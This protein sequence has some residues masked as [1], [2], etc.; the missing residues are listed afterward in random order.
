TRLTEVLGTGLRRRVDQLRAEHGLPPMGC[1]PNWFTARLPL[2]LVG[3]V[4]E[5]DYHRR[6]LSPSVHYVGDC[7]WH[8]PTE[9]GDDECLD[10]LSSDRAWV[11]VSEGTLHAGDPFLLRA[12]AHGL[13]D[14]PVEAILTTS[15]RDPRDLGQGR[16]PGNVHL[17]RWVNH[18]TL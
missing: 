2:Y 11:H 15:G 12:A 4:H 5:L 1:S 8:A 9:P 18:A 13:A 6:D 7:T 17:A 3:N 14:A 10:A 16:L